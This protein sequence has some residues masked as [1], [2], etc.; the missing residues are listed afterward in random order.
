[1][2]SPA[3]E[4]SREDH[5]GPQRRVTIAKPLAVGI[6]EVTFA[7][8]DTCVG[9]ERIFG[10]TDGCSHKPDDDG[11]QRGKRPVAYVSWEDANEY[12]A[13]LSKKTGAI[14]RLPTE[15]EWEYS[16]R[17]STTKSFSTGATI[18][19][20]Q[21]S[22]HDAGVNT[23]EVGHFKPNAF[24]LHDMHG[25]VSE[26]VEDC[27]HYSYLTAPTDGSAWISSCP[28]DAR[29]IRGGSWGAGSYDLRSAVRKRESPRLRTAFIGFRVVRTLD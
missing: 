4:K 10:A 25:N 7:E 29:V 1:M 28:D 6:F 26:W 17:A 24:G 18:T 20:K 23:L 15:A 21:A 27:W 16:A 11:Y 5:E 9:R 19:T 3:S 12:L 22:F 2:G 8:W 14:Y 13:W